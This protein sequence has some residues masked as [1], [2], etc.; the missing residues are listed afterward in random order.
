MLRWGVSALRAS[1]AAVVW[2]VVCAAL[3]PAAFGAD[4]VYWANASG[5]ISFASLDGSGGGI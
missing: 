3:A 2:V 4:R 5:G 1:F